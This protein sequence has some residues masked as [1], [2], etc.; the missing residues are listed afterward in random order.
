MGMLVLLKP[1]WLLGKTW[2]LYWARMLRFLKM[3]PSFSIFS[4]LS[5]FLFNVYM[6]HC[7]GW[8]TKP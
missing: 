8:V 1:S 4:I 5:S 3:M 7:I 6:R 2:E